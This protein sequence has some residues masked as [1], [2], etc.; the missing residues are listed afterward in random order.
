MSEKFIGD[1][2]VAR[3]TIEW[4]RHIQIRQLVAGP[5]NI[6]FNCIAQHRK[7]MLEHKQAVRKA[8]IEGEE[9]DPEY[10]EAFQESQRRA[11]YAAKDIAE[12]AIG[13]DPSLLTKLRDIIEAK[14]INDVDIL[15]YRIENDLTLRVGEFLEDFLRLKHRIP[16]N[17]SE[18][19]DYI[20]EDSWCYGKL[21]RHV[22]DLLHTRGHKRLDPE[23]RRKVTK[24]VAEESLTRCLK[25]YAL[26]FL[27]ENN[28]D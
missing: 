28:N 12:R 26:S 25:H 23:M 21:D 2:G 9:L 24:E 19:L 11:V 4:G 3:A 7:L 14:D 1:D 16:R 17:R 15:L 22:D 10:V 18:L 8:R 5:L 13:S 27:N 6:Q 20:L